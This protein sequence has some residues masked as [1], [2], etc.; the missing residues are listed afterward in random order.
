[1]LA[2]LALWI[3]GTG[4]VLMTALIACQVFWRYVL[5]NSIS[6]TEP[7]QRDDHGLVHLPRRR[8]RHP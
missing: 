7:A 5:N 6:W 2:T 3:A 1:M 4:L 8:R